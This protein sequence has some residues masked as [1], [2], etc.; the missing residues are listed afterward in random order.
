M[1]IGFP[2]DEAFVKSEDRSRCK[3]HGY[4]DATPGWQWLCDK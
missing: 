1:T 4:D 2:T 3:S